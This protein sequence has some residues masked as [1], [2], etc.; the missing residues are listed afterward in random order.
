MEA[1]CFE[2]QDLFCIFAVKM[3]YDN[4]TNKNN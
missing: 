4:R 2:M 3:K 1:K